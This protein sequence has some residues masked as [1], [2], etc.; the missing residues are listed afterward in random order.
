MK[1]PYQISAPTR[2]LKN[3]ENELAL[4]KG[5][6]GN[7]TIRGGRTI[8]GTYDTLI[9]AL[10]ACTC[11]NYYLGVTTFVPWIDTPESVRKPT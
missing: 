1:T 8:M 9:D 7:V 5:M 4:A 10:S 2:S 11:I 3:V 6:C